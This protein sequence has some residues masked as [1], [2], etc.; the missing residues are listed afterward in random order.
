MLSSRMSEVRLSLMGLFTIQGGVI[1]GVFSPT[2]NCCI[3]SHHSATASGRQANRIIVRAEGNSQWGHPDNSNNRQN[4]V[5][6]QISRTG[7]ADRLPMLVMWGEV[8]PPRG[9]NSQAS[10]GRAL[11]H[12]QGAHS[13]RSSPDERLSENRPCV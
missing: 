7:R 13:R 1:H 3:G 11:E 8:S 12:V 10:C 9:S 4:P 6:Y 5:D 2:T